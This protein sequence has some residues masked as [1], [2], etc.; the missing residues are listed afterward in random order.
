MSR[1]S[2]VDRH[3]RGH[4]PLGGSSHRLRLCEL[5][6]AALLVAGCGSA[7][8]DVQLEIRVAQN[9]QLFSSVSQLSVRAERSGLILA[10]RSIGVPATYVSLSGVPHGNDTVFVLDGLTVA[11]DVVATGQS[12]PIDYESSGERASIF[13]SPTNLFTPT[14]S[15]PLVTRQDP[16]AFPLTDGSIVFSGGAD[17]AGPSASTERYDPAKSIFSP[18]PLSLSAPRQAAQVALVSGVGAL[19][20]GGISANGAPVAGADVYLESMNMFA[21]LNTSSLGPIMNHRIIALPDGRVLITG[22]QNETAGSA[23]SATTF[24]G[25]QPDGSAAIG[26]G[27]ALIDARHSHMIAISLGIPIVVGGYGADGDPIAT[28]EAMEPDASP[29]P[30]FSTIGTLK[31]ARAEGTATLLSD[32][33]ILVTGGSGDKLGTPLGDAEVYN[34]IA[35]V[36]QTFPLTTARRGHTAT[37]LPN[38]RVL[39]SGGIGL[40]GNPLSSVELFVPD[41]GFVSERPLATPRSGHV[42]VPLCDGT[43]LIA[44]GGAD[45][46]IY[47]PSVQ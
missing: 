6:V 15:S 4:S 37:L 8:P 41:A 46:E 3:P 17:A 7:S 30:M 34:P 33:S 23:L 47:T 24:V 45:A 21:A 22:G 25:V 32:G 29:A 38:G 19:V 43:V 27:P 35:R 2:V 20:S 16:V 18:L 36:T 1:L 12:C 14:V 44:G 42:A 28:F 13:F 11:G 26:D 31:E 39:I 5:S 10:Q 9:T 40:D